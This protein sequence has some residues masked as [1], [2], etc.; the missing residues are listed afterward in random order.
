MK[1]NVC[2]NTVS[3]NDLYCAACG[4]K[5]ERATMAAPVTPEVA[6]MPSVPAS[7]PKKKKVNILLIV[8]ILI[9]LV[10]GAIAAGAFFL[11]KQTDQILC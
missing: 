1:C 2:G 10:G 7:E 9:I 5:I 3:D 11:L 4:N 6:A 8:I